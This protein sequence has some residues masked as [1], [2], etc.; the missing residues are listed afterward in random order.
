MAAVPVVP[1]VT[2]IKSTHEKLEEAVNFPVRMMAQE[3]RSLDVLIHP[4]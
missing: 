4:K 3:G 1:L 2:M